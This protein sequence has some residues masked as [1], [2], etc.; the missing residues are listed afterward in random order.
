MVLGPQGNHLSVFCMEGKASPQSTQIVNT[1]LAYIHSQVSSRDKL[2]IKQS[3]CSKFTWDQLKVARELLFKT[4]DPEAHYG[5]YGPRVSERLKKEDAFDGIFEKL[6]KLDAE[7]KMPSFSV[8]SEELLFLLK[9]SAADHSTCEGR[10]RE[11]H[12]EIEDLRQTFHTVA[13]TIA[14]GHL[15]VPPVI[16]S[17]VPPVV[18]TRLTSTSS[19]KRGRDELDAQSTDSEESEEIGFEIPRE[20]RKRFAKKAKTKHNSEEVS[21]PSYTDAVKMKGK[22][23]PP[24]TWGTAKPTASFKGAVQQIFMYHCDRDVTTTNVTDYL[25]EHSVNIRS[26]EKKSHE[27]AIHTSFRLTPATQDDYDK[28][29]EASI[30]PTQVAVRRYI[31]SKWTPPNNKQA[32][33][34]N[35]FTLA[36]KELDQHVKEAVTSPAVHN[37]D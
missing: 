19:S 17:G 36:E 2:T 24:S 8:P 20:Q 1:C 12:M 26:I 7:N 13:T 25:K 33:T 14:T 34:S 28:I 37:G 21:K 15:P 32:N 10:F 30:L 16:A 31:P 22:P 6:G 9:L 11:L 3:T 27:T 18:R 29:M 5:Y 4:A 23:K 35:Q